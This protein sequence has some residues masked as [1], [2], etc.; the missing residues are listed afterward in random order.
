MRLLGNKRSRWLISHGR[1]RTPGWLWK[2]CAVGK[3]TIVSPSLLLP[4]KAPNVLEDVGVHGIFG[5]HAQLQEGK[6]GAKES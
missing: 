2:S 3:P 6:Q 5:S 4:R 1:Q